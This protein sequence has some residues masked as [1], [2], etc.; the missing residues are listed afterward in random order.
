MKINVLAGGMKNKANQSQFVFLTAEN[1]EH[2][3]K[4]NICVSDCP[5]EKY[6]LYPISP[7]SLRTR[8]LMRNKANPSTLLRTGQS[9]FP[10][11][12]SLVSRALVPGGRSIQDGRDPGCG[13]CVSYSQEWLADS[14]YLASAPRSCRSSY[15]GLFFGLCTVENIR[16]D[17]PAKRPWR[18]APAG[19]RWIV[20][21]SDGRCGF[22]NA[23][24]RGDS[25]ALYHTA[26]RSS[27]HPTTMVGLALAIAS[28]RRRE[29]NQP[30]VVK[31]F[32]VF[33]P[34]SKILPSNCGSWARPKLKKWLCHYG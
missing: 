17:V 9:Q 24:G 16:A 23:V 3:E 30:V 10:S 14:P 25:Q 26:D 6:A 22:A 11:H 7:C 21:D 12:Q 32:L 18:W 28:G 33:G 1:P 27:S 4:N 20:T 19:H 29:E 13:G 5:I 15:L 31:T 34:E 8:R 2:A